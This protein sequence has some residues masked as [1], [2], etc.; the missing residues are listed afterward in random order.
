M[1][2]NFFYNSATDIGDSGKRRHIVAS[3]LLQTIGNIYDL[4]RTHQI[5]LY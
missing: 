4:R 5:I 2:D 3:I 1:L